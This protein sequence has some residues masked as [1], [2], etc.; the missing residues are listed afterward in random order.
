MSATDF[1]D[2]NVLLYLASPDAAKA[3]RAEELIAGG[4]VVSIQVLDEFA[5]VAS[6][7]F[8]MSMAEVRE[9]L[10]TIRAV[11]T[12]KAADIETHE[13]GL[14]IAERFNFSIYDSMLVAAAL[15]A[16]C[17]VF[18]TEDLQHGQKTEGL[19]IENPFA[20]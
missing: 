2:S 15:R 11:C 20:P 17:K 3:D 7:K 14:N 19:T 13:L 18:Y 9:M 8:G 1:F 10:S 5:S 12:I 6:R 16:G 4:G